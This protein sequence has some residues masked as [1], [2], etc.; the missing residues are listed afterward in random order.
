MSVHATHM[1]T[2]PTCQIRSEG[3]CVDRLNPPGQTGHGGTLRDRSF[4][5]HSDTFQ[6]SFAAL[7]RVYSPFSDMAC[8][9]SLAHRQLRSPAGREHGTIHKQTLYAIKRRIHNSCI[10]RSYEAQNNFG[11]WGAADDGLTGGVVSSTENAVPW[12]GD[13]RTVD[14][15]FVA[16]GSEAGRCPPTVCH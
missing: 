8:S 14:Y 7:R 12:H 16:V 5:T 9:L 1:H 13:P 3:C 4:L 6:R 11:S 10:G 2:D 15:Y